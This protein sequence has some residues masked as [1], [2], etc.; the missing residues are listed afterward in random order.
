MLLEPNC[1][2]TLITEYFSYAIS[3]IIEQLYSYGKLHSLVYTSHF[4]QNTK[5]YLCS[6]EGELPVIILGVSKSYNYPIGARFTLMINNGA[7]TY[8]DSGYS[9]NPKLALWAMVLANYN[10]T[11]KF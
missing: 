3:A 4:C 1:P 10:F 8:I 5:T 2:Y 11:V 7:L 6:L 9:K